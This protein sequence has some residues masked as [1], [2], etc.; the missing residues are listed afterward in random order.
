MSKFDDYCKRCYFTNGAI[1][2]FDYI[3]D[4]VK[5]YLTQFTFIVHKPYFTFPNGIV[6]NMEFTDDITEL[7]W[8]YRLI[9]GDFKTDWLIDSNFKDFS[10]KLYCFSDLMRCFMMLPQKEVEAWTKTL[11]NPKRKT[12]KTS[13]EFL[14]SKK[15]KDAFAKVIDKAVESGAKEDP[16]SLWAISP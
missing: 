11:N 6:V 13:E 4:E 12:F 9:L 14:T 2:S 10:D 1:G 16:L 8:R 3:A 7:R 5:Q 15:F